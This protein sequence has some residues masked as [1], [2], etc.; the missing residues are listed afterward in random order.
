MPTAISNIGSVGFRS[1]Q[2]AVSNGFL[3]AES[4]GKL[5]FIGVTRLRVTDCVV[6]S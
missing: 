4:V 1:L 5:F 6:D 3:T 2:V